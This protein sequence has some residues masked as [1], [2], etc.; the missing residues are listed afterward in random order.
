M[1]LS[2]Y[3]IF[4]LVICSAGAR[5]QANRYVVFF[6]D[7]NGTPF[8]VGQPEQFLSA[9]ALARRARNNVSV[10]AED[11]PVN[12][13]YIEE[14]KNSGASIYFA[15]RWM[16][17]VL[18][19]AEPAVLPLISALPFV[20][21]VLYTAP[22]KKLSGG[23]TSRLKN[24]KESST[25]QATELQLQLIGIDKM[26]E[27]GFRGEGIAV[28][29]FDAGFQGVDV[30]VPFQH[31]TADNRIVDTFDFIGR[32][33]SVFGYDD[34]GTEVLSVMAAFEEGK[35]V[36]GVYKASYYL[37]VTEDASS[38]Y[39]VEEFNWL[40]AAE[41]ADSAGVDVINSSLGYNTFDDATMDYT[42]AQLDGKTAVITQAAK[43]AIDRGM[44]VV[45]SAGN[46]GNNAWQLV[47]PPADVEGI[48]AVGSINSTLM[49]SSFSSL[50]PTADNRIK[51]DVVA[52]GSGTAVVKASGALGT[53]SG[54]SL[55][56]P[57]VASLAAGILQSHSALSA[58]QVYQMII[59]SA[60]QFS[61]PD[62]F[63][64]YGLPTYSVI[65]TALEQAEYDH[66]IELFPNPVTGSSVTLAFKSVPTDQV[67]ISIYTSEGREVSQSWISIKSNSYDFSLQALTP[68][69]YIFRVTADTYAK[70]IKVVKQ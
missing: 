25:V 27:D 53:S 41:R 36:G 28:A 55:A 3:F 66:E 57:L 52:L 37:Y 47:T 51:P 24:R 34:H 9:R 63:K 56:S 17:C 69:L 29:V 30:S 26:H 12:P 15:S 20:K 14:V 2:R 48:L 5:A 61:S 16:N 18:I 70:S 45:C 39:K 54:T 65:A 22:N 8:S 7:K 19:E 64:G 10:K 44:V 58:Q 33:G 46:E 4:F 23:R 50:G 38:E 35:Y 59:Q 60:D 11:L 21:S 67:H 40:F 32:S 1:A 62:Q 68:G 6:N 49:K 43:E 31:L 42:K 13:S